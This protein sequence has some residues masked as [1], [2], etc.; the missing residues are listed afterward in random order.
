MWYRYESNFA[1]YLIRDK[2]LEQFGSTLTELHVIDENV[3]TMRKTPRIISVSNVKNRIDICSEI[4]D[5]N[6][7]G[8]HHITIKANDKEQ[9]FWYYQ[10]QKAPMSMYKI[11][12]QVKKHNELLLLHIRSQVPLISGRL[13]YLVERHPFRFTFPNMEKDKDYYFLLHEAKE[14]PQ[15]YL[16]DS[17]IPQK[18]KIFCPPQCSGFGLGISIEVVSVDAVASERKHEF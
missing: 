7:P 16:A 18:D 3:T 14:L 11:Q 6:F 17:E 5:M 9:D 4:Q 12:I 2:L 15:F 8:L 1:P 13:Y 10:P